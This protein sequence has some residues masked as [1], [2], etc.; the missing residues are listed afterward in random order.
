MEDGELFARRDANA[1]VANCK[2]QTY[3][4]LCTGFW[5][6]PDDYFA[7]RGE[8]N[9]VADQVDEDLA[10]TDRVAYEDVRDV[11]GHVIG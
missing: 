2:M 7:L 5:K 8:L 6:D 3:V 1:R 9:G 10:Q 11:G 4:V